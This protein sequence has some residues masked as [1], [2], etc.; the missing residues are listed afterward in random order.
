MHEKANEIQ[1]E[2][3]KSADNLDA[4]AILSKVISITAETRTSVVKMDQ[5][6]KVTGELAEMKNLYEDLRVSHEDFA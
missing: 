1:A 4:H 3:A 5:F 6:L 2:L